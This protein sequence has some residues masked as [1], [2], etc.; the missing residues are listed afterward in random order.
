MAKS[1]VSI[2]ISV[3]TS[4][5]DQAI[6]KANRLL[7]LLREV[8]VAGSLA[9][10]ICIPI[11]DPDE[12]RLIIDPEILKPHEEKKQDKEKLFSYSLY[13]CSKCREYKKMRCPNYLAPNVDYKKCFIGLDGQ[14]LP[15]AGSD[16]PAED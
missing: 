12:Y 5:I 13:P 3:D 9:E 8:Q 16:T 14:R 7:E 1:E 11:V 10:K 4:E 2:K 6:E 15:E